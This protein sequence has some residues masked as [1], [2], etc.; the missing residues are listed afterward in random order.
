MRRD[1][2][3]PLVISQHGIFTQF[4]AKLLNEER[5]RGVIFVN[6]ESGQVQALRHPM[7]LP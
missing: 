2:H 7:R 3:P 5:E 1:H 4:E 6:K